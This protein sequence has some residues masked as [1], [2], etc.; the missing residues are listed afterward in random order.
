MIASWMLYA[1]VISALV[2]VAALAAERVLS[3]RGWPTRFVWVAALVLSIGWPLA[4]MIARM[5]PAPPRPVRVLPFTIVVDASTAPIPVDYTGMIDNALVGLWIA[6][7]ALLAIRLLY[8]VSA[9]ERSRGAWKRG[10]VNGVRVKLSDNVGPAVVGLRSME[11]VLP[12][13][14][15]TLDEPL[16]ALVL[17]HEEEHRVA[18]DPY[19]LFGAAIAVALLPWNAALWFQARRLRLAIEMDCDERVLRAHPSPERYGMLILTIA[20]RR[21]TSPALFAPMMTE[22]TTNLERRIIAM[23]N[24][25]RRVA[26]FT[27]VGGTLVA[28]GVLAFASSLQ[29]AG[30]TFPKAQVP[31]A[32][33]RAA[34]F[35]APAI[36][37]E[38]I[39]VKRRVMTTKSADQVE[40]RR[41][42]SLM[43]RDGA[44]AN[45]A[46]RYPAILKSAN[47]EGAVLVRYSTDGDGRV[48]M[49]TVQVVRSTHQLFTE[50]VLA[51]M[52]LW[53]A[54]PGMSL[55][56][57]F[58]FVLSGKTATEV[59]VAGYPMGSVVITAAAPTS[60]AESVVAPADGPRRMTDDQ[61]YFEFQ[62]EK[63]ASPMPGNPAP[64]YPDVLR[65]A[66]VEGEVLAQ[67][68]LGADGRPDMTSFKVLKS[69]HDLFSAAVMGALPNMRFYPAD[70]GG[71]AV[72]QLIQM[73]FHFNLSKGAAAGPP[74]A[75]PVR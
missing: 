17:R 30:R 65:Q 4:P 35:V 25:T 54:Q 16:R 56:T 68:V 20:Q 23:K 47:I 29:S 42:D 12:E 74:T 8:G 60:G 58:L 15:M 50:S 75:P 59:G 49:N 71:R 2:S 18:R 45:P 43:T 51:N 62:V 48:D 64:R 44:A 22:P 21:S 70:V 39:P 34:Q 28:V 6:L 33:M 37:P 3:A 1:L 46:P 38:T 10:R 63:T 5:L 7:S 66:N 52:R 26:R 24:R 19:L 69:S 27:M 13:W 36:V 14:I 57:P 9:V 55:E 53:R 41:I 61:T 40:I 72:K 11:V 32:L 73:P 31:E 67:F